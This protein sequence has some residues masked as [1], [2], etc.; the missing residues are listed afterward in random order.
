VSD[1]KHLSLVYQLPRVVVVD[2]DRE[3]LRLIERWFDRA[4]WPFV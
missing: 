2:C 4:T 1:T 3:A